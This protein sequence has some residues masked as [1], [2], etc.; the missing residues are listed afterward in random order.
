MMHNSEPT[1][2]FSD[3]DGVEGALEDP[4][5]SPC[6]SSWVLKAETDKQA[7]IEKMVSWMKA[8]KYLTPVLTGETNDSGYAE[9]W[10]VVNGF[11]TVAGSTP[12]DPEELKYMFFH[13]PLAAAT[14]QGVVS[15]DT[16]KTEANFWGAQV[17][18]PG[19]AWHNKYVAVIE[20]PAMIPKIIVPKRVLEGRILPPEMIRERFQRWLEEMRREKLARGPL[21]ILRKNVEVEKVKLI[22]APRYSYYLVTLDDPRLAAVFNAYDASFEELRYFKRPQRYILQPERIKRSLTEALRMHRA[23]AV[24][25]GE[26]TLRYDPAVARIGRLSPSWQLDTQVVDAK[27]RQHRLRVSLNPAG[28]VIKGLEK[29]GKPRHD[30]DVRPGG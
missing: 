25:M 16:W 8:Y 29:L 11:Q 12:S 15:G 30:K 20:P 28:R 14:S 21:E 5:F 27:G 2:W 10:L 13:D 7:L 4:V 6:G 18:K 9:H 24:E 26:P 19:S 22:E 1:T 3:P 17:N 23:K